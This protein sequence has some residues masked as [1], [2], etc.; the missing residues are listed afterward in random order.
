MTSPNP[1]QLFLRFCF[2]ALLIVPGNVFAQ[3]YVISSVA[4]GAPYAAGLGNGAL[5]VNAYLN[6]PDAVAIDSAG[7]LYIADTEDNMVRKV[8]AATRLISTVAGN[9]AAA[10]SGDGGV[11]TAAGL[12]APRGVAIDTAGNLLIADTGNNR[13]RKVDA[14]GV[15]TT[16]AGSSN[17]STGDGGLATSGGLSFPRSVVGDSA[18]NLY[19]ADYGNRRVRKVDTNGVITTLAGNGRTGTVGSVGDN[20]AATSAPVTPVAL[21]LDTNGNLYI[22]DFGNNLI[23]KVTTG[24]I[25][26]IAGSGTS[27]YTGD[28][29][30]ATKATLQGPQGVAVDSAGNVFI[31]DSS[32][33]VIREVSGG[34]ITT[35]AGNGNRGNSGDGGP[36]GAAA[37][38]YPVGVTVTSAGLV[39]IANSTLGSYQ[40][41]R[42]RVL[43]PF[44]AGA[45][46]ILTNGV[47]PVFG[48]STSIA[49]GSWFSIYGGNL[50][51]ATTLW[52]ADFPTQLDQ[53]VVT[54]NSRPAYL[55]YVSP[56]QI[57]AQAPD[58]STG[59]VTVAV[60]TPGGTATQTVS[61]S[62]YS[63]SLSLFNN[64]YPVAIVMTPGLPGNSGQGFDFI[65]PPGA[66]SFPSRPAVTGETVILYGVGFGPTEPTV[67]AG[68][69]FNGVA[70]CET[71][72]NISIGDVPAEVDFA[73][74]VQAGLY[75]FN[76]V[77]PDAGSGDLILQTSVNGFAAQRNI[78]L[79]LQ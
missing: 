27:G 21:A 36:A 70:Y 32:N 73:G 44:T 16:I 4:G 2:S 46:T 67:P 26:T 14:H 71:V 56:S 33:N 76:V 10:F 63:P 1:L 60:T 75:Q 9:G 72:P 42:I 8:D 28:G 23:R 38:D 41:A 62:Q 12:N 31:A 3:G 54:V 45:P 79:T 11:A 39:Y 61:L 24:T 25:T 17:A 34:I 19:I 74:I 65:G 68:K 55:W 40:D 59:T 7:N 15:M 53:V 47:V 49:P 58:G 51:T 29:S 35:I 30:T 50:A 5:A 13:I 43:T 18:G 52:N 6:G 20:G 66:F 37:L 78:Y 22:A 57:N 48:S 69:A 77:V 64:K